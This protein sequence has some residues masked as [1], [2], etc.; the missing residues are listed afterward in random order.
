MNKYEKFAKNFKKPMQL[1]K[2]GDAP[3]DSA[4]F[5][6]GRSIENPFA[7]KSMGMDALLKQSVDLKSNRESENL[8]QK[9]DDNETL[10]QGFLNY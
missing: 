9:F 3:K 4:K 10:S 5:S 6:M 8:L 2:S 1:G 7:K